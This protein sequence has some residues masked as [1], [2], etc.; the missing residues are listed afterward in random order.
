MGMT[1]WWEIF[2]TPDGR[3]V[4][5]RHWQRR[6]AGLSSPEMIVPLRPHVDPLDVLPFDFE[7]I[8]VV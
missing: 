6:S 8:R 2:A 5:E 3:V 4:V 7:G 1:S